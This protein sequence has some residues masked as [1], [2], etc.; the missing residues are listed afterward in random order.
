MSDHSP[1]KIDFDLK[2]PKF[3]KQSIWLPA[4]FGLLVVLAIGISTS[5]YS[6]QTEE[7]GV[8]TR[9]GR[10]HTVT[11]RG[12]HGKLPFGIDQVERVPVLRQMKQEFG[13][14]TNGA[15]QSR[16]YAPNRQEQNN[17]KHMVTG[18]LNAAL[19]EWVIQYRIDDPA[20]YLFNVKDPD[21]V[22]RDAS[23][24]IMREVV[25]D[26]TVDEVITIGRQDIE[27]Q[28]L[29]KLQELVDAYSMGLKIDQVQLKNV[30]PPEAVQA[31]FNEVNNAQQEREKLINIATGQYNREVPKARGEAERKISEAEGYATERIN[32][33]QGDAAK[34]TS[35]Y[36]EYKKAP[37][38]TEKRLYLETMN[39]VI[40]QLGRKIIIDSE[41]KQILPLLQLTP[42]IQPTQTT[43]ATPPTRTR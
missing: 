24:A 10:L 4:I 26:R 21:E 8:V 1:Q 27:T 20:H 42:A 19:V 6:V 13:F 36:I 25:G 12:L 30:D 14:G 29:I 15:T 18:D 2:L 32:E 17:E 22:L 38:I 37:A 41:A 16:Q 33:A 40:P 31:S 28:S 7:V 5:F 34:F 39:L 23:E 9:F 43:P 35:L 3:D 11:A